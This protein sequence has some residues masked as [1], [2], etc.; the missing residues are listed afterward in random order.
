MKNKIALVLASVL[1]MSAQAELFISE[2]VEGG[3]FNKAIEIYNPDSNAVDLSQYQLKLFQ[4]ADTT[5]P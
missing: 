2:Y 1:P 4:N 5:C 3:S